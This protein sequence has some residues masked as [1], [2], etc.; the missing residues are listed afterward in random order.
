MNV[1]V[2]LM[3]QDEQAKKIAEYYK[4]VAGDYDRDYDAPYWRKIYDRITWVFVEPYLP[5]EGRALDAGGGTGKWSIPMARRGLHVTLLDISEEMLAVANKKVKAQGLQGL[6]AVE[7]G[8]IRKLEFPSG[9]FDF[10]LAEGDAVSYC[11]DAEQAVAELTRV[12]K[13]SMHIVLGVDSVYPLMRRRLLGD[14]DFDAAIQFLSER[15]FELRGAGFESRAF[16]PEELRQLLEESGLEVLKII[17]KPVSLGIPNEK[18]NQILSDSDSAEKLLRLQ[19]TLC[20]VPSIS[21]FGGH[22]QAVARKKQLPPR[23]KES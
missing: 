1:M 16:T 6:I 14:L 12:L 13:P 4:R 7:Q 20:D 8:D 11:G 5:P 23:L 2:P 10:V 19:M 3:N 17:G 18:V 15:R 9:S 21:G 22:L